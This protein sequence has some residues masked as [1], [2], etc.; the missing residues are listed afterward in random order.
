LPS[1]PTLVISLFFHLCATI[2]WIG[3]LVITSLLVWPEVRRTLGEHPALYTLLTR[4]RARF[5]P[6][7]N[8]A[9]AVLIVTGLVQMSLDDNYDG[10]L[11]F[12]NEWSRVM[13]VKHLV[14]VAMAVTGVI[15]QYGVVPALERASLLAERGKGDP[16]EWQGLRRRE[17]RLTWL[18]AVLGVAVLGFSAWAGSI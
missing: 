18:N 5:T 2:V 4:L 17:I 15:L 9:L 3:G 12:D 6:L 13:L 8:L 10:F 1:N 7:S 11:T 16:D 14:I